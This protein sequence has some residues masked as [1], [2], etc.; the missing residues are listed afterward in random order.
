MNI[1]STIRTKPRVREAL[2]AGSLDEPSVIL[3]TR[4]SNHDL[5]LTKRAH[6]E[7]NLRSL[8]FPIKS[9]AK[10]AV[11]QL[12]P[13][14]SDA[15]EGVS[16]VID[17]T[18]EAAGVV[19]QSQAAAWEPIDGTTQ[20]SRVLGEVGANDEQLRM[21]QLSE[22]FRGSRKPEGIISFV[23]SFKDER[24]MET[25]SPVGLVLDEAPLLGDLFQV[26]EAI[27]QMLDDSQPSSPLGF[28]SVDPLLMAELRDRLAAQ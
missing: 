4:G 11:A 14:L 8:L 13:G 12:A 15:A 18:V 23:A 27:L 20:L 5:L 10:A 7:P 25:I 6:S 28:S 9:L 3:R 17:L 2:A 16:V 1:Q 26:G 21:K 22:A 24:T 19:Q